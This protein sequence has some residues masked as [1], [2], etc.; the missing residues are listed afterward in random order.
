MRVKRIVVAAGLGAVT[1]AV[2]VIS[3][4]PPASAAVGDLD[5][6]W[7]NSSGVLIETDQDLV[8]NLVSDECDSNQPPAGTASVL[9]R[10]LT[11]KPVLVSTACSTSG[12]TIA[13]GGSLVNPWGVSMGPTTF[14][15]PGGA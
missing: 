8:G 4:A 15:V 11:D 10:N 14:W 6:S 9:I 13:S 3:A 5:V 1:A 12:T 2:A 7:Y